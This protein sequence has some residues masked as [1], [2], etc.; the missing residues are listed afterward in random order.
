[1]LS[2][3]EVNELNKVGQKLENEGF[4]VWF[5]NVQYEGHGFKVILKDKFIEVSMV[6]NVSMPND[7]HVSS[8]EKNKQHPN[9]LD[10]FMCKELA[11]A[12]TQ[13]AQEVYGLVKQLAL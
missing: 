10:S 8:H 6:W 5:N 11:K 9:I 3:Q 4:D 13:K 1:M 2:R 12:Q 7:F